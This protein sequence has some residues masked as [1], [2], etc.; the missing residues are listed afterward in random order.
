MRIL[1]RQGGEARILLAQRACGGLEA[2]V[3]LPLRI[4]MHETRVE[5]LA[6]L[7]VHVPVAEVVGLAAREIERRRARLGGLR[8]QDVARPAAKAQLGKH[9]S[10][11]RQR[12]RLQHGRF[13]KRDEQVLAALALEPQSHVADGGP[14]ERQGPAVESDREAAVDVRNARLRRV[15]LRPGRGESPAAGEGEREAGRQDPFDGV[16]SRIRSHARYWARVRNLCAG[17]RRMLA[18]ANFLL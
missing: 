10:A 17:R 3:H 12:E 14:E 18:V 7:N 2:V 8:A 4:R 9:A 15:G 1:N 13:R 16:R 6:P 11:G 5:I